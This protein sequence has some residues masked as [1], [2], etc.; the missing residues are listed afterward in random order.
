[1]VLSKANQYDNINEKKYICEYCQSIFRHRSS[2]SR[3]KNHRCQTRSVSPGEN[4]ASMEMEIKQLKETQHDLQKQILQLKDKPSVYV[5]NQVLQVVCVSQNDNYLDMLIERWDSDRALAFIKDCALSSLIGDCKLIEKIYSNENQEIGIY[6]ADKNRTK[7][8]YYNEK[9]E[10]I[11]DN[12]EVFGR[13]LASNLQNSYL[14][15]VNCLITH[16]LENRKCP[17]KFLEDYDLQIWNQHIFNLS[18]LRYQKKIVIQL[19]IPQ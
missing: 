15:G 10:I 3:H 18:D 19:N 1:M 2:L 11:R 9:K 7:I 12:K 8:E 16:N 6:F 17:N 13:K 5:N 14:K 4:M